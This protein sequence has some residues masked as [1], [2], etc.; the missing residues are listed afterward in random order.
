[1]RRRSAGSGPP[2]GSESAGAAATRAASSPSVSPTG[3]R[4][5][6]PREPGMAL[7][8]PVPAVPLAG[9]AHGG[10]VLG[11][12]VAELDGG[13]EPEWRAV[14]AAERAVVIGVGQDG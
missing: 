6:A 13:V 12:L 10:D 14:L 3:R 8:P 9:E 5:R 1:M 7:V 2:R 4:R 11:E